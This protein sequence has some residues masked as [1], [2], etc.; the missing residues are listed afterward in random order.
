MKWIR[1]DTLSVVVRFNR[2]LKRYRWFSSLEIFSLKYKKKSFQKLNSMV[3]LIRTSRAL[4]GSTLAIRAYRIQQ[5]YL[6]RNLL[7]LFRQWERYGN[8]SKIWWIK[9]KTF[10]REQNQ[11][12]IVFT[13]FLFKK[14]FSLQLLLQRCLSK[15]LFSHYLQGNPTACQFI[16]HACSSFIKKKKNKIKL[17]RVCG[18]SLNEYYSPC[19]NESAH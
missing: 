6:I 10:P 12:K 17:K 1:F 19:Y 9:Q 8:F 18:T 4:V 13:S 15:L 11:K 14:N 3:W 7:V 16:F 5:I 2:N